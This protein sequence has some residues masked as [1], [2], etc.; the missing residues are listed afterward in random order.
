MSN[1]ISIFNSRKVKYETK[2]IGKIDN[3]VYNENVKLNRC[4]N[5]F[6]MF[7]TVIFI[8]IIIVLNYYSY[9]LYQ[10]KELNLKTFISVFIINYSL[11][12]I[13]MSL[14]H[15]VNEFMGTQSNIDLLINYL[16]NELPKKQKNNIN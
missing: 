15:E 8:I 16:N 10:K 13:F 6:R 7:Y 11:L 2:R 3:K 4:R 14:Y 1:L 12:D 5:K 9:R